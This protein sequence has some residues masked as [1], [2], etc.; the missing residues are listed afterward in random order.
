MAE[1]VPAAK[2]SAKGILNGKIHGIPTPVVIA[3]GAAGAFLLYRWYKNRNAASASTTAPATTAS[4]PYG[5]LTGDQGSGSTGGGGSSALQPL[6][7]TSTFPA[8]DSSG[9][10]AATSPAQPTAA[11]ASNVT[12]AADYSPGGE[13]SYLQSLGYTVGNDVT[14]TVQSKAIP[15]AVSPGNQVVTGQGPAGPTIT[16]QA[17]NPQPAVG[18]QSASTNTAVSNYLAALAAAKK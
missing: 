15:L 3:G 10:L 14:S 7:S 1:P 4:N 13:A 9:P 17:T 6:V 12:S 5:W 16:V 8:T 2:S 11:S 18:A